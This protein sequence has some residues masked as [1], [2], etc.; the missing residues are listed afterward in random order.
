MLGLEIPMEAATNLADIAHAEEQESKR[1]KL[2][3]E[4]GVAADPSLYGD[5]K[6][7]NRDTS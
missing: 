3:S 6:V 7:A 4:E 2:A 1:R 5:E